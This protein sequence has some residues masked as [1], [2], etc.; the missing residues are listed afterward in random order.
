MSLVLPQAGESVRRCV[1]RP[2]EGSS[3]S[4]ALPPAGKTEDG[5][6][7]STHLRRRRDADLVSEQGL[8]RLVCPNRFYDI[9][10][11]EVYTHGCAVGA[12]SAA[13]LALR[14]RP[15]GP[16]PRS[17]PPRTSRGAPSRR[18][19][20]SAAAVH[21]RAAP[22]RRTIQ[23]EC[24]RWSEVG[25]CDSVRGRARVQRPLGPVRQL[26]DID[27]H[28]VSEGQGA[29]GRRAI[30]RPPPASPPGAYRTP[31]RP[32]PCSHGPQ[33]TLSPQCIDG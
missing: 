6:D 20:A 15:L 5:V 10:L 22:S 33:L 8:E 27:L 18:A 26:V 21:V 30:G 14:R 24:P 3:S 7:Q 31:S 12:L 32:C 13:R 29:A 4:T 17:G 28:I 16:P 19:C 2:Q 9:A 25:R 11:S 1:G 23:G